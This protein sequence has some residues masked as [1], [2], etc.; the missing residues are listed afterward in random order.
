MLKAGSWAKKID[1]KRAL[2]SEE[3]SINLISSEYGKFIETMK[4]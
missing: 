2:K 4:T 3:L 1:V